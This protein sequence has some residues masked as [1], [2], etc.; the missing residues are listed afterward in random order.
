MAVY[1]PAPTMAAPNYYDR[2]SLGMVPGPNISVDFVAAPAGAARDGATKA[3]KPATK[4]APEKRAAPSKPAAAKPT[5][6]AAPAAAAPAPAAMT[7]EA[8]RRAHQAASRA[9]PVP[10]TRAA[11]ADGEEMAGEGPEA[12][13]ALMQS[14]ELLEERAIRGKVS[15]LDELRE[16][17]QIKERRFFFHGDFSF[18]KAG[19]EASGRRMHVGGSAGDVFRYRIAGAG[20]RRE[21][22]LKTGVVLAVEVISAQ[23]SCPVPLGV[24]FPSISKSGKALIPGNTCEWLCFLSSLPPDSVCRYNVSNGERYALVLLPEATQTYGSSKL[25]IH[26]LM[27]KL[28]LGRVYRYGHLNIDDIKATVM[29]M[30][31]TDLRLVEMDSPIIYV[32]QRNLDRSG[33]I[34]PP[35]PSPNLLPGW[36]LNWKGPR[37]WEGNTTL[38]PQTLSASSSRRSTRVL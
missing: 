17:D 11:A 34:R 36:R 16:S 3:A 38:S 27:D 23:S 28:D 10:A 37:S 22:D 2:S 21:G 25:V 1:G 33:G 35:W 24:K 32:L 15:N 31:K 13:E 4:A 6:A 30:G 8:A 18:A 29:P 5:P 12:V 14:N 26:E 9:P 7:V 19:R 20:E